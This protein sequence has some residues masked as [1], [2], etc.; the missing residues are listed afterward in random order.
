MR[1]VTAFVLAVLLLVPGVFGKTLDK[2][3]WSDRVAWNCVKTVA[4]RPFELTGQFNGPKPQDEY[5]KYFLSRLATALVRPGGIEK[6]TL[7][8][9]GENV[10]A[11]AVLSG[12]FMELNTGSRAARFWVGYGA[13]KAKVEVRVRGYRSDERT[14]MFELEQARIAPFS[15]ADDANIGDIDA[16]VAD[17]GEELLAKRSS[18]V[19]TDLK[20]LPPIEPATLQDGSGAEISIESSV[21]DADVFVDGK[22]VGNAPL[23]KYRLP[24]G[25]HVIEVRATG[26]QNWRRDLTVTT[27]ASSRVVAQLEKVPQ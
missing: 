23:P 8:P 24:A 26:Y 21:V 20:P 11:D 27:N 3:N 25:V 17:I 12:E 4:V 16:V 1:R 15:L 18:C 22:F 9:K 10:T 7:V 19:A 14:L 5:M 2:I 13:G 6:V